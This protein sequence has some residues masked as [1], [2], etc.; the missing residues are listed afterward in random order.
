MLRLVSEAPVLEDT[1]IRIIMMGMESDYP[2]KTSDSL[3]VMELMINR[4]AALN[5]TSTQ[6]SPDIHVAFTEYPSNS[7]LIISCKWQLCG[8]FRFIFTHNCWLYIHLYAS[9]FRL[10]RSRD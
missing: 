8:I 4:A 6:S 5:T 10:S 2:L 3:D 1:L 9:I 7:I